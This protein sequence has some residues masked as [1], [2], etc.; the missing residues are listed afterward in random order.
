MN[1]PREGLTYYR[2]GRYVSPRVLSSRVPSVN[3]SGV[4]RGDTCRT[5]IR[6]TILDTVDLRATDGTALGAVL[7]QPKRV[8]LLVYL[9]LGGRRGYVRRDQLLALFWPEAPTER[10]R[11]ALRQA[12]HQ[13]RRSLGEAAVQGRSADELGIPAEIV[14][15]D[16]LEFEELL[17]AG[18]PHAALALYRGDLAPGLH[19]GDAP[20]FT[21]W[22]ETERTRL[23]RLALRAVGKVADQAVA[24]GSPDQA[25][26]WVRRAVEWSPL[27]EEP[28]RRL[29]T[30]LDQQGD[31]GGALAAYEELAQRVRR[32][33]DAGPS[34]ETQELA[35]RI[36]SRVAA[37]HGAEVVAPAAGRPPA[38]TRPAGPAAIPTPPRRRHWAV[39][40][41]A[42]SLVAVAAAWPFMVS[43]RISGARM[44]ARAVAVA[45]FRVRGADT[46]LAYL[47]EGMLDLLATKFASGTLVAADPR[48]VLSAWRQLSGDPLADLPP[49]DAVRVARRLGAGRLLLGAVVG[50]P[51]RLTLSARLLDARTGATR[52]TAEVTGPADSLTGLID[53]MVAELLIGESGEPPQRLAELA[54]ASLPALQAYLAGREAYRRGAYHDAVRHLRTATELDT[55][56][57]LAWLKLADA[58]DWAT[59]GGT[60]EA[61]H[62]AIALRAQLNERDAAYLDALLDPWSPSPG[63]PGQRLAA[64]ERVVDLSPDLAEGWYGLGDM[65][66]HYGRWLEA[67]SDQV[68]AEAAFGRA[69]ALDSAYAAPLAHLVQIQIMRGE[70]S[71]ILRAVRRYAEL[72]SSDDLQEFFR[73]RVALALGDSAGVAAE[74]ARFQTSDMLTLGRIVM[75]SQL[76]GVGV[77]DGLLASRVL[78]ALA[79]TDLQRARAANLGLLAAGNTGQF[80]E[81]SRSSAEAARVA[82]LVPGRFEPV[83]NALYWEADTALAAAVLRSPAGKAE[84]A[85]DPN[86]AAYE[87][88]WNFRFGIPVDS[89]RLA[90][91][92][93]ALGVTPSGGSANP[94][95]ALELRAV[96]ACRSG[97]SPAAEVAHRLEEALRRAGDAYQRLTAAQLVLAH[98]YERLGDVRSALRVVQRRP[99]HQWIGLPLLSTFLREEGRYAAMV[100]DTATAVRAY[101]HYLAL[102]TWADSTLH[103]RVTEV[104][105]ALAALERR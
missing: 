68:L 5:M 81:F 67:D 51:A 10:A 36:R 61:A 19:V 44:D 77:G 105:T 42:L 2:T 91:V 40:V 53:R 4:T 74:R 56:F 18:K 58:S 102:R 88:V 76:E 62:R 28:V 26:E 30:L 35:G 16:A 23:R 103:D 59:V 90:E 71:E 97:A 14:T 39:A 32:E 96:A 48:A 101:R 72:D 66:F 24:A 55:A 78:M 83:H 11:N 3:W 93:S 37:R 70:R 100:G 9:C 104:R 99:L 12:V 65:L 8:G 52:A 54:S 57:A 20:G 1:A 38:P 89:L 13:L 95:A 98:C 94:V 49:E 22:L 46:G 84:M 75:W 7:A 25:V 21:E 64:W 86:L 85:R 60:A 79:T 45:P 80:A 27:E 73:W 41:T 15:C 43:G 34:A 63:S 6:L 82:G 17:A 29:M 47:R 87:L 92:I 31:R 50:T 69:R 33:L